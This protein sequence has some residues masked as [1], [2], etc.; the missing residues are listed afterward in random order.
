MGLRDLFKRKPAAAAKPPY[1]HSGLSEADYGR[2]IGAD[3]VEGKAVTHVSIGTVNL[4]TGRIV[5]CDPLVVPGTPAFVR[6]VPPGRYPVRLHYVDEG[7]FGARIAIATLTISKEPAVHYEMALRPGDELAVLE[8]PGAYFGFPVDAGLGGFMDEEVA[9]HYLAW[10]DRFYQ[11]RPDG[12]IY[13]DHF[14][15]EFAKTAEPGTRDGDWINYAFPDRPDLNLTMFSSGYGDGVYP[16]YWG[17][18]EHG[19]IV[20][21]VIDFHVALTEVE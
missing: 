4:P 9:A 11:E 18:N 5:V 6:S 19:G 8:E 12:N 21:L 15:A 14:A 17:V 16:S 2:I 3:A 1:T 7:E 10:I 20:C 13:D